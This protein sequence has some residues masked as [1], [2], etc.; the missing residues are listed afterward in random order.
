MKQRN[1]ISFSALIILSYVVIR[2][3]FLYPKWEKSHTEATVSWDVFGYYLYLPAAIIYDD[4]G[5]LGFKDEIFEKYHP[6]GD[7]HHAVQQPDGKWVM[8]YPV[9]MAILYLPFFLIGHIIALSGSWPADGFSWPYQFAISM[10]MIFYACMGLVLVRK[11][12][13]RYFEDIVAAIV[14]GV[15]VLGTNW[16]NYAAID[17]AMPH[18]SLFTIYAL[19]LLLTIIWHENPRRWVAFVMGLA[20][21]LATIVRP[22]ELMSILIPLLWGI[23]N[24]HTFTEK[25]HLLLRRYPDVLLLGGGIFLMGMMQMIYWKMYAGSF[26]HYSY[27]EFGFH[28][29]HPH[30]KEGFFSFRKGWL[31]YTPIMVFALL[32]FVPLFTRHREK[33]LPVLAYFLINVYVVFAWEVWW[34]GGSFGARALVQSYAILILPL[35]AFVTAMLRNRMAAIACVSLMVLFADL[36]LVMTWQ[37]HA[38]EGGWHSEA[39][40]R[41]YYWKILGSTNP[42][43]EDKKFLDVRSE[44]RSM[45]GKQVRELYFN[46][47]ESDSTGNLTDR[48]VFSGKKAYLLNGENQFS[49]GYET[50][51][52]SLNPKPRSW[53]RVSASVFFTQ[54]VWDEW[55]MA[56]LSTIFF[57]DGAPYRETTARIQRVTDPWVWFDYHYEMR[58]PDNWQPGDVLKVYVWN[59]GSQ[60]ELFVDD[61]KVEL[62]EPV[63]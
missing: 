14:L 29:L 28:W 21:G 55:Q 44:I 46:D 34:Y 37:A 11:I 7:F 59:A 10:G 25:I 16:L 18:N 60:T 33:F 62:I 26:L 12:L 47:F 20:I 40:T 13:L 56:Q 19:V 38:K 51:L 30:I 3:A 4:L 5:G 43:K 57:R 42:R 48:Q 36:N 31:L 50:T 32:G 15:I 41:A 52:A 2:V 54:M 1:L 6:A 63:K 39:M 61:L 45:K 8:K 17:G 23:K 58:I 53:V 9:G 24:K 27:G 35:A 49:P 22:T